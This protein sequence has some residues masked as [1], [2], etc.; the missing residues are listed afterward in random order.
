MCD[1]DEPGAAHEVRGGAGRP[2]A[3]DRLVGDVEDDT[4]E[5]AGGTDRARGHHR[6]RAAHLR[7]QLAAAHGRTACRSPTSTTI[8]TRPR[9]PLLQSADNNYYVMCRLPMPVRRPITR[10]LGT[11]YTSMSCRATVQ[12]RTPIGGTD[13]DTE[14][15]RLS[16]PPSGACARRE[17]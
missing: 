14:I 15:S 10:E 3:D 5:E 7:V 4:E 8:A 2:R 16:A 1:G 9:Q 13:L 17:R 6:A 12:M 11:S